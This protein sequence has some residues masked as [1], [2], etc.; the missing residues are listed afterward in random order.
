[1]IE[2]KLRKYF[3][4]QWFQEM[5]ER[6]LVLRGLVFCW[7]VLCLQSEFLLLTKRNFLGSNPHKV[8]C[9]LSS[10]RE[11]TWYLSSCFW[12]KTWLSNSF[13]SWNKLLFL[14]YRLKSPINWEWQVSKTFDTCLG[15]VLN[16]GF[17]AF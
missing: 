3:F 13:C 14:K 9:E 15:A 8:D 1:M 4:L 16:S 11:I 12:G 2:R 6:K 5:A 7:M 10:K 17:G